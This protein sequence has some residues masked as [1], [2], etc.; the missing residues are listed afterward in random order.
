M[1]LRVVSLGDS[2]SCGEGVGLSVPL[3]ATWPSLLAAA[4]PGAT[5]LPLAVAGSKVNDVRTVQLP[6]AV[7]AEPHLA[8]LLVGLNDVARGGFRPEAFEHHLRHVVRALRRT[9]ATVLL[10]RLHD[11]CRHLPLPRG[12]RLQAAERVAAVN[13]AVDRAAAEPGARGVVHVLDLDAVPELRRREAWAVDRLHPNAA[14]HAAVARAAAALLRGVGLEVGT[15]IACPLPA[16]APGR[17]SLAWWTTRH[18]LPWLAAHVREVLV[19]ALAAV[20]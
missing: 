14:A 13:T 15:P 10:G 6:A 12:L 4:L 9:G 17:A 11:P 19:P 18:G 20:R 2:T 8:T 7:A 16:R 1:T 3:D 5:L